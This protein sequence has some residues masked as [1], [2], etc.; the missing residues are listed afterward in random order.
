MKKRNIGIV[1]MALTIAIIVF[2]CF[3]EDQQLRER[4][5]HLQRE[6]LTDANNVVG[7]SSQIIPGKYIVVFNTDE[8]GGPVELRIGR[9]LARAKA[10]ILSQAESM[11]QLR[12]GRIVDI[13][14]LSING[15]SIQLNHA[16]VNA[17]R[18]DKRVRYV[19]EDRIIALAPP[20]GRGWNR[21]GG[22]GGAEVTPYGINRVGG[23]AIYAGSNVAWIIDTGIDLTHPDLNVQS[24][25]GFSVFKTGIDAQLNDD[26]GHGTH[27]AGT[28]AAIDNEI[29]VVG[30]AAGAP[31]I[32]VK[33]L[34]SRGSGTT[35]GVITGVDYVAAHGTAG[36]V[37]NMSLGGSASKALDDAVIAA[38][39]RGIYF[40]IAAGNSDANAGNY[41]P[42]RANGTNVYTIS[43]MNSSDQFASF[44]NWGNSPNRLLCTG[45]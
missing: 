37:A 18:Q 5:N 28:V 1:G 30:V 36:D 21:D 34:N 38:A 45:G 13:F 35:S 41:S 26:Y 17:L 10:A 25:R 6:D 20:P 44:S 24:T 11:L 22:N 39:S 31:V 43:A 42:A 23:A 15:F 40:T 19:E 2:S 33:V 16:E 14:G 29:G 7:F 12:R 3:P 8:T 32:P 4:E 9:D 27:V